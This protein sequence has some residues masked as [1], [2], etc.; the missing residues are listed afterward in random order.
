MGKVDCIVIGGG[1]VG[2]LI[3][4]E[5]AKTNLNAI[6]L[7]KENDVA[8]GA[9]RANSGIV[10]AGYD[11]VPGTNK[12]KFNVEGNALMWKLV[13]ELHV[14]AKQCGSIVVAPKEGLKG[15]Q[16][17]YDKGIKN[18]VKVEILDRE[19]TLKIEP[20]ISK[21]IEYS[22]Y[23]PE[24][25]I[26]SPYKLTI[27]ATDRAILNGAKVVLEANV[28][29]LAYN[30]GEWTVWSTNGIYKAKYVINCAGAGAARINDLAGACH[31]ETEF[32]RG[33]YFVLDSTEGK[34]VSTVIFPLP[35]EKG[36]GI[37]VAPTADGN[38]IYGP[39]SVAT[40]EGDTATTLDGFAEIKKNVA[41]TYDKPNFRKIIRTYAGVRTIVG[42]DFI[43]E[44]SDVVPSFIQI[45]G[46]CSPGLSS[47]PAIAK[48]VIK[49]LE[50]KEEVKYKDD[51]VQLPKK[52]KLLELKDD[53]LNAL[54]KENEAWGRIV[55]RCEK[56]TEAE[57]VQAIHSPLPATTVDAVKRRT[58]AGMGRCQGG[59]CGTRVIEILARETGK[60]ISEIKKDMGESQIAI[61]RIKE[62]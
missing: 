29:K 8:S 5:L 43:V 56:I 62:D 22:L 9:S 49:L 1:V 24:A 32:R 7:E 59:F 21:D 41:L 51:I 2:T 44:Y 48:Y 42:H 12:A 33:D 50:E 35:T 55:C 18:G 30:N 47:A 54:I 31:Y 6:L 16:E 19:K 14:P 28:N 34:A 52:K 3:L 15:I 53:E 20:N 45:L 60:T 10:H 37:L 26:V 13:E 40:T 4:D 27:A 39:T 25:G 61:S 46:I 23:A 58:R 38:V 36:K 57:I 11:C 17:L